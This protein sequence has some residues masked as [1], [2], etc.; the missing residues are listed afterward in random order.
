MQGPVGAAAVGIAR[1]TLAVFMQPSSDDVMFCP[2]DVS[3]DHVGVATWKKGMT[4]G[5]FSEETFKKY[6]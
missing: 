1:N 2:S 4:F 5:E 3:A 6:Y